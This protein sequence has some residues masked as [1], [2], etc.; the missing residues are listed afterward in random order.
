MSAAMSDDFA[1]L[2]Q[3]ERFT[4]RFP[5]DAMSPRERALWS[6]FTDKLGWDS[7]L[8]SRV[9]F[10]F[11]VNALDFARGKPV[12]D[13]G[14]GHQR[15]RPFF[16]ECV[17][18]SQEHPAGIEFK[19]MQGIEYDLVCP[20]D[21]H[22]PLKDGSLAAI[23][24][25]SVLE[26]VR[27]PERFMAEAHR[28]LHPGGRLY[29]HVPFA[30]NEHEQPYDFQRPTRYGLKAWLQGAGFEQVSV[31]PS[32]NSTY[33]ASSYLLLAIQQEMVA[34]GQAQRCADMLPVLKYCLDMANNATDDYI[35]AAT[36][37][38]VG[39]VAVAQKA[40]ALGDFPS[41]NRDEWLAAIRT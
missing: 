30:Y 5:N 8:H 19:R 27:F 20:I 1:P 2:Y 3:G 21:E 33:G 28:V 23:I 24:S 22:I 37:M 25:T 38:P 11:L 7:R 10:D 39:W 12:L 17:Y 6:Y 14:A 31:L 35:D 4:T 18:L 34:R 26:H 16:D 13:A 36:L 41:W 15:Y 32:S 9:T 29:V 40:G